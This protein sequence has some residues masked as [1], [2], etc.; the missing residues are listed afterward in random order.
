MRLYYGD[1]DRGRRLAAKVRIWRW[2]G[3]ISSF[4]RRWL[5]KHPPRW[6]ASCSQNGRRK[7]PEGLQTRFAR[8]EVLG[9][10]SFK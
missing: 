10:I 8:K 4:E 3:T 1:D 5:R 9:A 2:A 7:T 6:W